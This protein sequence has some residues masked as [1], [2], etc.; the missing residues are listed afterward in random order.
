MHV[1]V[2]L[3]AFCCKNDSFAKFAVHCQSSLL[4]G[5][6]YLTKGV[7]L[8]QGLVLIY[9]LNRISQ[10]IMIKF[11]QIRLDPKLFPIML[12]DIIFY[13]LEV[14]SRYRDP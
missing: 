5:K 11:Y 3:K 8:S 7:G 13:P 10:V 6:I 4:Y 1:A 2:N 9:Y 12:F 14:V